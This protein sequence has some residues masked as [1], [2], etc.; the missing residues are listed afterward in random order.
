LIHV[1]IELFE[2]QN[3]IDVNMTQQVK[4]LL[5]FSFGLIDK[6]IAYV[7]DEGSNLTSLTTTSILVLS[8][9]FC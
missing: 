9:S 5:G 2:I 3:I 6:I 4:V 8:C 7:K 1:T